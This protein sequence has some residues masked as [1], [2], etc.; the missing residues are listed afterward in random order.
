L[1]SR[2]PEDGRAVAEAKAGGLASAERRSSGHNDRGGC[3]GTAAGAQQSGWRPGRRSQGALGVKDAG[4]RASGGRSKGQRIGVG[5]GVRV[6]GRGLGGGGRGAEVEVGGRRSGRQSLG[7]VGGRRAG[8]VGGRRPGRQ[9]LSAVGRQRVAGAQVGS[10]GS[11]H[12]GRGST[13]LS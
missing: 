6:W 13:D 1:V 9:S 10:G 2:M 4:G 7:A 12:V 3:R 11:G 8:A 5:R